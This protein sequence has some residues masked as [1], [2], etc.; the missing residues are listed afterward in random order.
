MN[1]LCRRHAASHIRLLSLAQNQ[2][3]VLVVSRTVGVDYSVLPAWFRLL[4][5]HTNLLLFVLC[6]SYPTFASFSY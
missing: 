5:T 1:F 4:A 3:S 2:S 6:C